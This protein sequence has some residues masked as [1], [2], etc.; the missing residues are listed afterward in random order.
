MIVKKSVQSFYRKYLKSKFFNKILLV[1]LMI[2][3]VAYIILFFIL[4]RNLIAIKSDQALEM[5]NQVLATVDNFLENKIEHMKSIHQKLLKDTGNWNKITDQLKHTDYSANDV[6]DN[7]SARQNLIETVHSIDSQIFGVFLYGKESKQILMFGNLSNS[8][9]YK[10]FLKTVSQ[11]GGEADINLKWGTGR[12]DQNH[13]NAFSIFLYDSIKDPENFTSEIGIMAMCFSSKNIKQSYRHFDDYIKGKIYVLDEQGNLLFDSSQNYDMGSSFPFEAL[14]NANEKIVTENNMIYNSF[15]SESDGYYVVNLIPTRTIMED[16]KIMQT[17]IFRVMILVI[18]VALLVTYFSTKIFSIRL[19]AIKEIMDSVKKGKLRGFEQKKI[20]ED[21]VGY[22]QTELFGMCAAL[23]DHIKKEYVYQLKQKE[24]ELYTL[25]TQINP[26]FLYNSLE[27]I[28][29]NLYIRG[30]TEASKMIRILSE[31]FRNM[32][33]KEAIVTNRDEINYLNSY[34]ELYKF[35]L[36]NR[37]EYEI[38][39]PD[40]VYHYATIKHIMQPVLE[41]A[42]IHGIHDTG[43]DDKPARILIT[44]EMDNGD[45]L[46]HICDDGVGIAEEELK[47]IQNNLDKDTLFF[48]SIGI[49]NVNSRLKIVYGQEYQL[50]INS[51]I[52]RGTEVIIRTKAMVKKELE[53]YVQGVNS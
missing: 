50:V 1:Y 21:E 12:S 45:I 5:S 49:Y 32:M 33:K 19:Q 31:M 4:S 38:N 20:Y 52:N 42:L 48:D 14:K 43:T 51:K 44:A 2:T 9:E 15:H 6:T 28:R 16:V 36:G 25:Q 47:E 46:F 8:M 17:S 3:I 7:S 18:L 34:L 13:S 24:M 22:I 39:I 26:H 23:D 37:M 30:E 35:R 53:N 11:K 29:M 10:T 41:N 27:S 40:E